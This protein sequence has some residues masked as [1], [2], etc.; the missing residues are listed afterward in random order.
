MHIVKDHTHTNAQ[1]KSSNTRCS[2]IAE[3]A[4]QG[5]FSIFTKSRRLQLGDNI[6]AADPGEV[7]WVRTNPLWPSVVVENARTAWLYQSSSVR[8]IF[9]DCTAVVHNLTWQHEHIES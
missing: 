4:I 5:A 3:T 2:A 1:E 7:R 8:D 9:R 6:S